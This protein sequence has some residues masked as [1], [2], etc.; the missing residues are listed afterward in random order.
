MGTELSRK[1]NNLPEAPKPESVVGPRMR[2]HGCDLLAQGFCCLNSWSTHTNA[3]ST[4]PGED[5]GITEA[6][7]LVCRTREGPLT[8]SQASGMLFVFLLH[9]S[10]F[11][12]YAM[13]GWFLKDYNSAWAS[14]LQS[15]VGHSECQP[16]IK[17]SVW[18]GDSQSHSHFV[19]KADTTTNSEGG[20]DAAQPAG[21]PENFPSPQGTSW[22]PCGSNIKAGDGH[23]SPSHSS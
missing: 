21:L 19:M 17:N 13:N 20:L 4:H 14:E 6:S 8:W 22:L 5:S 9:P 1:D 7:S 15:A 16:D 23:N 12:Y 3:N 18:N 10:S 11:D 2:G